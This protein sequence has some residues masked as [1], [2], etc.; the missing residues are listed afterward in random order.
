MWTG[1]GLE[2]LLVTLSQLISQLLVAHLR[3]LVPSSALDCPA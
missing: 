2:V 1:P 3:F